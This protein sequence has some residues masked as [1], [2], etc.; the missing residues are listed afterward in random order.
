MVR[1]RRYRKK[2]AQNASDSAIRLLLLFACLVSSR[3]DKCGRRGARRPSTRESWAKRTALGSIVYKKG[4]KNEVAI[5]SLLAAG[6]YIIIKKSR[7]KTGHQKERGNLLCPA[8]QKTCVRAG[9]EKLSD[10]CVL[11]NN[12]DKSRL[13][14][15]AAAGPQADASIITRLLPRTCRLG[16]W[17]APPP[18]LLLLLLLLLLMDYLEQRCLHQRITRQRDEIR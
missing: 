18:H 15:I 5:S 6:L 2:S 4:G 17:A 13:N 11:C 16:L 8:L 3:N 14:L 12:A 10:S 7:K 9:K 1:L